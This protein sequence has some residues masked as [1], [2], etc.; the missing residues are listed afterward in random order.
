MRNKGDIENIR[1]SI[2]KIIDAC[3]C[4]MKQLQLVGERSYSDKYILHEV[5]DEVRVLTNNIET[6]IHEYE[7]VAEF[8][9]WQ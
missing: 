5:M 7:S 4:S 8:M 9:E 6:Q 3:E 1:G 2:V